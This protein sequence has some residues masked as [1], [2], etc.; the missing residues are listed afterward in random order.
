MGQYKL[1]EKM[2]NQD[3]SEKR[4]NIDLNFEQGI[5]SSCR[6]CIISLLSVWYRSPR[7]FG[8]ERLTVIQIVSNIEGHAGAVFQHEFVQILKHI[9]QG[10]LR[11]QDFLAI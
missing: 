9:G 7:D 6:V 2:D 10:K 11:R 5:P 1:I 8:Q 3:F 4:R